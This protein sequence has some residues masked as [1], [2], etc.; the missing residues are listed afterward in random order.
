MYILQA[1]QGG[2]LSHLTRVPAQ[3]TNDPTWESNE[4]PGDGW[5]GIVDVG[6]LGVE[7]TAAK[8]LGRNLRPPAPRPSLD[9]FRAALFEDASVNR[10]QSV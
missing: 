9:S 8:L 1:V 3:R 10:G 7:R 5:A 4:T 2:Q 6:S